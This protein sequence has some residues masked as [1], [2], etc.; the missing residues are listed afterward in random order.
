MKIGIDTDRVSHASDDKYLMNGQA[1][2]RTEHRPDILLLVMNNFRAMASA[3][4]SD[5]SIIDTCSPLRRP[6]SATRGL[7]KYLVLSIHMDFSFVWILLDFICIFFTKCRCG[8]GE[9]N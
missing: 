9:K 3:N 8:R 6:G 2:R 1:A 4:K 5:N 7:R